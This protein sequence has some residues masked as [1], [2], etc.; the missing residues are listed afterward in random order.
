MV[1]YVLS[2]CKQPR[3]TMHCTVSV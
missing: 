1:K 3:K 2:E